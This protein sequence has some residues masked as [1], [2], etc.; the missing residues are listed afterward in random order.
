MLQRTIILRTLVFSCG[1]FI[2]A[3]GVALS[4]KADL[5]TSPVSCLPYVA[6][7]ALPV[8][9]GTASVIMNI[10][11]ILIQMLLLRKRFRLLQLLQLPVSLAFGVFIDCA[12]KL[13]SGIQTHSY[14]AQ[15][16]LCFLS[17]AVLAVGVFLEVQAKI[18]YLPGEGLSL[19]IADMSGISFGRAKRIVDCSMVVAGIIC[20]FMLIGR[21]RGIRE[22]TVVAAVLVGTMTRF[23]CSL[24]QGRDS[25]MK[26][27]SI[28]QE[29]PSA[30]DTFES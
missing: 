14:A 23:L 2:M 29:I 5:G 19:A 20:S 21:L 4:I 30:E 13:F 24:Y 10:I 12:I 1:L 9:V 22:G 28:A 11:I 8:S 3:C 27:D 17:C 6:S 18:T 15:A 7:L 25:G 26:Q 16:S